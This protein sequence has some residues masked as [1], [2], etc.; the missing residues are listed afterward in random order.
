VFSG[1]DTSKKYKI[2]NKNAIA[3]I[4]CVKIIKCESLIPDDYSGVY[5]VL[6]ILVIFSILVELDL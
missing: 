5:I 2:K 1:L 3:V 6:S 4:I